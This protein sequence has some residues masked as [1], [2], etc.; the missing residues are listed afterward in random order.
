MLPCIV[1][2]G[3]ITTQPCDLRSMN[4]AELNYSVVDAQ[5]SDRFTDSLVALSGPMHILCVPV[6]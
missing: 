5:H 4:P 6:D 3:R 2:N 1:D